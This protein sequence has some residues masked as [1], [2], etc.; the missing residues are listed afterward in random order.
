MATCTDSDFRDNRHMER[1]KVVT[2]GRAVNESE[3]KAIEQLRHSLRDAQPEGEWLL[4]TNLLF[5]ATHRQ[6]SDEIDI[7]VIGPPGVRVVEVKHWSAAYAK[8]NPDL[9]AREA[10]RV[11]RKAVKVGTTLKRDCPEVP[12]VY[13]VFLLTESADRVKG[14]HDPVRGVPFHTFKTW[15]EVVNY[16]AP[17]VLSADQVRHLGARLTPK[18]PLATHG[19]LPRLAGS[20]YTNLHLQTPA[21]ER[22]HRV[23][24]ATHSSSRDKVILHLYDCSASDDANALHKAQR[25]CEALRRLRWFGWAPGIVD[26]FQPVPGYEGEV[27]FFTV[28]NPAAPSIKQRA[29]D[30]S[31][32]ADARLAYARSAVRA[33]QQLHEAGTQGEAMLHR[34]LTPE[35]LLVKH[36]NSPVIT[37]FDQV[38]I[39]TDVTIASNR[40]T[41]GDPTTAPEV[42]KQGRGAAD[43]RSDVYSMCASLMTLFEPSHQVAEALAQGMADEPNARP[44]LSDLSRSLARLLGESH[45]KPPAPPVRFWTEDQLV[46][47][48]EH[49]YRIISRLGAGG[50][51]T[52]FKVVELDPKTGADLGAYVAKAI[53]DGEDAERV[54]NAYRLVRPHSGDHP[55]LSTVYQYARDW[56]D[57]GLAA[58]MTWVEGEPLDDCAGLMSIHAEDRHE[59]T[60]EALAIRWLKTAASALDTLH[61]N[62]LVHGDVSPRNMIVSGADIV[63]T[64]YDCVTKVG[65]SY[66]ALGTVTYSSPSLADGAS[67][68]PSDDIYALAA[69]FFY[70]LFERQP[71]LH[72]GNLTK[73]RGLSWADIDRDGYPVLAPFLD[74]ATHP[75]R[76]KR[77]ATVEEALRD[78]TVSWPER[79]AKA[80]AVAV[81]AESARPSTISGATLKNSGRGRV[82][83][84]P[85]DRTHQ[86][87]RF[88]DQMRAG[89]VASSS[90]RRKTSKSFGPTTTNT[91]DIIRA[92]R[93]D[94]HQSWKN[95]RKAVRAQLGLPHEPFGTANVAAHSRSTV[96]K[97]QREAGV[98]WEHL[99]EILDS[100]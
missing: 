87:N 38:R 4:L 72:D 27:H 63:L 24:K 45:P 30:R 57:N 46:P 59:A 16:D 15:R 34:N 49:E 98:S 8:R 80:D 86:V 29:S 14:L 90:G 43:P 81:V 97:M 96:R 84:H 3:R 75:K 21:E 11:A 68:Q 7:L 51:G 41:E 60:D 35:T 77:Y 66:A 61:R 62:G 50:I 73:D 78:L 18:V 17:N 48:Q 13:G 71:F 22:F 76:E 91:T 53:H 82:D 79:V 39:P 44:S 23:Y 67:A 32:D 85:P 47:F 20:G 42:R 95:L 19:R 54:M 92:I 5:S 36:D 6:Q 58:L 31:W 93:A 83:G 26:S 64:D 37:G 89:R 12:W 55:A 2:C 40:A 25:E 28:A 94:R 100:M 52:T 99:L 70:A 10:D 9:V 1:V 65:E 69:S 74:R 56:Q 88:L 33:L